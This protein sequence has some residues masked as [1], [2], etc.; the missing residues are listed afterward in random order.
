MSAYVSRERQ[1]QVRAHQL[2]GEGHDV[3]DVAYRLCLAVPTVARIARE[4]QHGKLPLGD[5]LVELGLRLPHAVHAELLS[6]ARSR[7]L[8]V[9]AFTAI[10]LRR[11]TR[12]GLVQA[13]MDDEPV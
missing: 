7:G 2:L 10:L 9:A 11:A 5:G 8:G 12:D 6:E 4:T 3:E 1:A 13:I